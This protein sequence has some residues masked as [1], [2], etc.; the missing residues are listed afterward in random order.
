[1]KL[2][3][4]AKQLQVLADKYPNALVITSSDDEGNSYG[5]VVYSPAAGKFKNG[6]WE[7]F[8]ND[9]A[10]AKPNAVCLN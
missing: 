4:Y 3:D 7:P 2:K 10:T 9:S 6:E 8:D 5:E 1:M